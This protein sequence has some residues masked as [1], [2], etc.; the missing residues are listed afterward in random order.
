M[1]NIYFRDDTFSLEYNYDSEGRLVVHCD[2]FEW[3]LSTLKKIYSEFASFLND[4]VGNVVYT[5]S[6]NPKFVRMFGG[7]SVS[8]LNKNG[9]EYEVMIW[10]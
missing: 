4:N 9:K 3:K 10:E 5:I 1:R 8:V 2:V 6:P 7:K